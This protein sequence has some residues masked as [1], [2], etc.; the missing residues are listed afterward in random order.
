M[1][2]RNPFPVTLG[3]EGV[4]QNARDLVFP[5]TMENAVGTLLMFVVRNI[6][7]QPKLLA[8]TMAGLAADGKVPKDFAGRANPR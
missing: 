5:L 2:R 8:D 7:S 1:A 4:V 3:A 6:F